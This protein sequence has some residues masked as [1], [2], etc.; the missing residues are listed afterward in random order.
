PDAYQ[1]EIEDLANYFYVS[2]GEIHQLFE[3][4]E[5]LPTLNFKID[6]FENPDASESHVK[7]IKKVLHKNKHKRLTRDLLKQTA[8]AGILIGIWL[9]DKKSPYPFIFDGSKY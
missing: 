2:T 3:L 8:A 5:A 7:T 1:R 4:I 9:G 6:S